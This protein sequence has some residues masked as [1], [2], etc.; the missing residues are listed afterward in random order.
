[1]ADTMP[2]KRT[3]VPWM[4]LVLTILGALSNGLPFT[5][6]P[7]ATVPWISLLLSLIGFVV[8]LFGLKRAFGQSTA[9]K[10]KLSGSVAAAFSLL[11]LAGAIVF[12]WSARHIPA[13][14]AAAPQVGQRVP[15]FTLPDST[16]QSV[17]LTQLFSG[18]EG[19][20]P[21]KALLLVFYRG[22]W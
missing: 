13:E 14:S 20:E 15:D 5:G 10:G 3:L 21:P 4:G 17:S 22:Y 1:M 7:A 16:G 11:F 2:R 6:F 18:S 8:V 19:K 12:F 9:Y